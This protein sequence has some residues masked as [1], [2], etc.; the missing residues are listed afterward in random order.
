MKGE[1][2]GSKLKILVVLTFQTYNRYSWVADEEQKKVLG[3]LNGSFRAV[4]LD[5]VIAFFISL[6]GTI[7]KKKV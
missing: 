4:L 1:G 7:W 6:T 2:G 5:R 3:V